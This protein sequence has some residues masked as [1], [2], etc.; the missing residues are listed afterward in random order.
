MPTKYVQDEKGGF[1]RPVRNPVSPIQTTKL[2]LRP[3]VGPSL[4]KRNPSDF[5]AVLSLAAPL[6]PAE[7]RLVFV[8]IAGDKNLA[9]IIS[10]NGH[11]TEKLKK[12]TSLNEGGSTRTISIYESSPENT[13]K[14][15]I[16]NIR[17]YTSPEDLKRHLTAPGCRI[18]AARVMGCTQLLL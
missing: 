2:I 14:G 7:A 8:K 3:T 6:T 4:A 16:H 17:Q 18:L 15:V 10:E 5:L 1:R 12:L 9:I 11:A 13:C